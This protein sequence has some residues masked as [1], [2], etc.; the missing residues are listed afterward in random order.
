MM[1]TQAAVEIQ[2]ELC[3]VI[4]ESRLNND[5][6]SF[7]L[8]LCLDSLLVEHPVLEADFA[9]FLCLDSLLVEH[10]V[11]EAVFAVFLCLVSLLVEHPVLETVFAVFV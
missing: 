5:L 6:V 11:L 1:E 2:E 4:L 9:V 8:F 10:P 3:S 7:A